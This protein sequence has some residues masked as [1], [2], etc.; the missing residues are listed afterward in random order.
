MGTASEKAS[1]GKIRYSKTGENISFSENSQYPVDNW[2]PEQSGVFSL[3]FSKTNDGKSLPDFVNGIRP[4][5]AR[6]KFRIIRSGEAAVL[7]QAQ[8]DLEALPEEVATRDGRRVKI[9][10]PAQG[11]VETL[12][13]HLAT[14]VNKR[15][16]T[17]Y[18]DSVRAGWIP[19]IAQTL[20]EARVKVP[21]QNGNQIYIT[22]YDDGYNHFVVVKSDGTIDAH[23]SAD[24]L[25]T[26]WAR[27]KGEFF[28]FE[29]SEYSRLSEEATR[30]DASDVHGRKDDAQNVSGQ[31]ESAPP[32]P[33]GQNP[34]APTSEKSATTSPSAQAK[35]VN[36]WVG[37]TTKNWRSDI[38]VLVHESASAIPHENLRRT[39]LEEGGTVE[40]FYNPADGSIHILA[41][42]MKSQADV[43]RVLR[44]EGMHWAFANVL[45][46]EYQ[47]LLAGSIAKIPDDRLDELLAKYPNASDA[48]IVEEYFAY[49]GQ[50]NPKSTAWRNFVYE[51]KLLL[52]KV[53]G[54]RV[55][56]TDKDILAFLS[57][58]N[59]RLTDQ[60]PGDR[61]NTTGGTNDQ[62][63]GL[64]SFAKAHRVPSSAHLNQEQQI[65]DELQ[66]R[67][68]P[69]SSENDITINKSAKPRIDKSTASIGDDNY[70]VA[71]TIRFE[72][73]AE[74]E[75]P[76]AD[77]RAIEELRR[78]LGRDGRKNLRAV[79]PSK[80]LLGDETIGQ[81]GISEE[82][83]IEYSSSP[84]AAFVAA[85]EKAFSKRVVFI[86]AD[87]LLPDGA[88]VSTGRNTVFVD[89]RAVQ[90]VDFLTGHELIH[91]IKAQNPALYGRMLN[92]L[93]P[94]A[95]NTKE[96]KK[97][98]QTLAP[99]EY[100]KDE[101]DD[102]LL[103]DFIGA[104]FTNA[105][106]WKALHARDKSLFEKIA[107]AALDIIEKIFTAARSLLRDP[108]ASFTELNKAR[109]LLTDILRE[110]AKSGNFP[111]RDLP[112]S[113]DADLA[114]A[115]SRD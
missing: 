102:E 54:D 111:D 87:S 71:K 41:D 14:S 85:Y 26:Q 31:S 63:G 76:S 56:F 93:L 52:R 50:N 44:H 104:Q 42:R 90:G 4:V 59:R 34:A 37:N 22:S 3:S 17:T 80:V 30:A 115:K 24:A 46:K 25:W 101:L 47:E 92:E 57:K 15:T 36:S 49:E 1:L 33:K 7:A 5:R 88:S 21:Q 35:T 81:S 89:S 109:E 110:Y 83:S 45:K 39:V 105:P 23:G 8:R 2:A 107:Q 11:T 70:S 40:G 91:A 100:R 51:T 113:S 9:Q 82:N 19:R 10:H 43:Q 28:G 65:P 97:R 13:T 74:G 84:V 99:G 29:N 53:F 79:R 6:S 73:Y 61:V 58:A 72:D 106:F 95:Q 103:G 27:R 112:E 69:E 75:T 60:K 55:E 94:M 108:S 96:Y 78:I 12:V 86:A 62:S 38:R 20:Q 18:A 32:A 64:V 16:N 67:K 48:T 66:Y 77:E 68:H 114:T 98:V